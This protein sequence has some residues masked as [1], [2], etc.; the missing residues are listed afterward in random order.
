MNVYTE[1]NIVNCE[2]MDPY[3]NLFSMAHYL[4]EKIN[5]NNNIL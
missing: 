1:F 4:F 5:N 2:H 3:K